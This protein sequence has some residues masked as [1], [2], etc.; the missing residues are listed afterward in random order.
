MIPSGSRASS[1]PRFSAVIVLAAVLAAGG[2]CGRAAPPTLFELLPP[3]STGLSFTNKLPEDTS[4][5][6]RNFIINIQQLRFERV[7][8]Q[9]INKLH[10]F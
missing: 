9:I 7:I 8:N 4:F 1:V 6:S 10:I 5:I 2:S 3:S